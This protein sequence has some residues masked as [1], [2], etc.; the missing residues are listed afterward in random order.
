[1][2]TNF[3]TSLD[4]YT[5][6]ANGGVIDASHVNDLQDAVVAL[7]NRVGVTSSAV[8]S[9]LTKR[10]AVLE[11]AGSSASGSDPTA[12]LA[13]YKG[14]NINPP[15]LTAGGANPLTAGVLKVHRFP[16]TI[17][18]SIQRLHTAH[19]SAGTATNAWAAIY[20]NAGVL[21]AQSD[22]QALVNGLRTYNFA[23]PYVAVANYLTVAI[24]A[25]SGT[26][27]NLASAEWA[28]PS[29]NYVRSGSPLLSAYTSNTGLTTT[30]PGTLGTETWAAIQFW[31][32]VS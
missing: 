28:T 17:G 4:S 18:S 5:T 31:V 14:W 6:R 26:S 9:S 25:A 29:I 13:G 27:G 7:E 24:W 8:A 23:A 16:I 19:T 15:E 30:A 2:A 20:T 22:N 32:A 21:V 12:V 11:A 3:P 10:I 1:M